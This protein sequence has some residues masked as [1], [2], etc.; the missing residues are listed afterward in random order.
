MKNIFAVLIFA[1]T[2]SAVHAQQF[3]TEGRTPLVPL[4]VQTTGVKKAI[5]SLDGQWEIN[6]Q[7]TQ[8]FWQESSPAADWKKIQV[9][10]EASMQ[11]FKVEH[12][13]PFVYRRKFLVPT[14]AKNKTSI[15]RFNG[16]YSY[17][18][19]WVNGQFIREYFGGFT[20]WDCD[21][22]SHVQAGKE[23]VVHVEVTDRADDIS[24]ASGYAHHPIG[25]ILRNVQLVVLPTTNLQRIYANVSLDD[26]FKQGLLDLDIAL[27]TINKG[28]SIEYT[29]S[30]A[31]GK[32][33]AKKIIHFS[34]TSNAVKDS[35]RI[36]DVKTWTA[37][38]PQLYRLQVKLLQN[39]KTQEISAQ[40]IGFRRVE[41]DDKKQL[42]VNG[43]SVKLRGACRHDMHPT[44]GRST[45][46]QQDSLD[47]IL[48]KEANLNFIR[49]SH[50]PPSKDFLEF[51]DRYG[52]YVQEETAICFVAQDRGGIYNKFGS[53]QNDPA[54]TSRYLG[55]LSEMI[56]HDRNHASV[57]MWSIGNES[58]YG[59]NFQKEYDFIKT[60]DQSRPVSWSWPT[61]A[62]EE[63]KRCFD[64]AIG[65]YPAYD[66]KGSDMGGIE[67]N[68]LHPD[69]P[70]LSDEWAHV[71]C[72]NVDLLR[73]DPNVKDYWGRSLDATWANRFDLAGNIGGAIWGMID[74]TFHMPDTITGYGP[75]GFIDVW[76]R[77]KVEFW[78]TKKAYSPIR[79]LKTSFDDNKQGDVLQ[80]PVKNRFDHTS[81]AAISCKVT[82]N[83]KVSGLSL[84][85]IMPHQEAIFSFD[86]K[87]Y[88]GG[89]A[90]LQFF[91][92]GGNLIDEEK[93]SWGLKEVAAPIA[94]AGEWAINETDE[95]ATLKKD[96][97][98]IF[99]NKKTGQIEKV[100]SGDK[101][102]ITGG[103]VVAINRPENGNVLKNTP[104][105]F[106]G[107]FVTE[108]ATVD[109]TNKKAVKIRSKGKVDKYPV[110]MT[111]TLYPS[112]KITIEYEADSIQKKTWDI[113]VKIP[114]SQ[115]MNTIEWDRKGY[116]TT[117]PE[118]HLSA[119][120]GKAMKNSNVTE[121]YR[122]RPAYDVAQGMNDYFLHKTKD[123]KKAA[124][125]STEIYR[126]KKE[127]IYS[128]SVTSSLTP[129]KIGVL[130]NGNQSAK[131]NVEENG[132]QYV[133]VSDKWDYWSL[134]WGNYQGTENKS[135]KRSGTVALII[136]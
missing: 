9:P 124:T 99:L 72:Y 106:S 23:A 100:I 132:D 60:I 89:S 129:G 135:Q 48:A 69:Y 71:A 58:S 39:G 130:S 10:G 90:L 27:N 64:I 119:I 122:E 40:S 65:H 134:S 76:R 118:G 67:K 5:S 44:L 117:Y 38:N 28:S 96:K 21:I 101:T 86:T 16:V 1:V 123:P 81:L 15:I 47:V 85:N 12:D 79:I 107:N 49:T 42:L 104:G 3:I 7:P 26:S 24:F 102:I 53:S 41:I 74:E 95:T 45:N 127:N 84:P 94:Q 59:S 17:A 125:N 37:E 34:N 120:K 36:P 50:Y 54:Y 78:N 116:W 57:I 128:Y 112:G 29:L 70:L 88:P 108:T 92:R 93:L 110:A 2:A 31:D 11:G 115:Q 56:D 62:L 66:G 13:K 82:S 52:I 109:L 33:V 83:G 126:A 43:K 4:P 103:L 14:D 63:G 114:I 73:Y 6:M 35:I 19:V 111:Y 25:G 18:R 46:R 98:G 91:D 8:S 131:I 113:G 68:M 133:L 77:K 20:A 97:I 30:A 22:S 87:K 121:Q 51:C 55:Q 32:K 61:S 136:E 75:W 105:I 80:I